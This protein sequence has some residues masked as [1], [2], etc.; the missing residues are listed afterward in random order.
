MLPAATETV[1]ESSEY[2]CQALRFTPQSFIDSVYNTLYEYAIEGM[3]TLQKTLKHEFGDLISESELREGKNKI[4]EKF[5]S[6]AQ[7]NFAKLDG[8]LIRNIFHVED[9]F[10]FPEDEI[11]LKLN[12]SEEE[13]EK[14]DDENKKLQKLRNACLRQQTLELNK[15]IN[16]YL[17]TTEF[18]QNLMDTAKRNRIS[19]MDE[20][21]N[22]TTELNE[23]QK[24]LL[25]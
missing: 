23:M 21:K 22:V 3:E 18:F 15:T 7:R 6:S 12:P 13:D 25:N 20:I 11:Q 1:L 5:L 4:L 24:L 17:K 16:E 19:S 9:E 2:I 10:V 8:Y 14:L